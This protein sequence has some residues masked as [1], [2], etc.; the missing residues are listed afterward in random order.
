MSLFK[1]WHIVVFNLLDMAFSQN[2]VK[3]NHTGPVVFATT[4]GRWINPKCY[5]KCSRPSN[6]SRSLGYVQ[7]QII[8]SNPS[9][10]S[11]DLDLLGNLSFH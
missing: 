5:G 11:V 4:E 3:V 10:S 1:I 6:K 2:T 7:S 9:G 8:Y